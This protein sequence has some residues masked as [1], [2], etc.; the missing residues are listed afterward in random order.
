MAVLCC[1]Q[2]RLG[3]GPRQQ[4]GK[5]KLCGKVPCKG[6]PKARRK[7]IPGAARSFF[8]QLA[9]ARDGVHQQVWFLYCTRGVPDLRE[10]VA[11]RNGPQRWV[12][13]DGVAGY[14]EGGSFLPTGL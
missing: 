4:G 2:T 9:R 1:S 6:M 8:H 7:R 13:E 10:G 14:S 3:P 12:A 11:G 5:C